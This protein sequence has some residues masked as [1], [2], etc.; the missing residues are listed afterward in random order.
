MKYMLMLMS[1]QKYYDAMSGNSS[2]GA[3]AWSESELKAMF[4]HMEKLN[5]DLV[6]SGEWV[7]AQGL[8]EP[9]QTRLVTADKD[10]RPVVSD[11]PFGETKEVLAGYWIVDV[12]T[13]E[14][15]YEIAA[16]AYSCPVPEGS[17]PEPAVVVRPVSDGP[18]DQT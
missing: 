7:D 18:P 5:Q 16:R 4:Q 14:R 2:P 9:S 13:P 8:A 15:A 10:G 6:A 12:E 1:A 17:D 3:P 11:G